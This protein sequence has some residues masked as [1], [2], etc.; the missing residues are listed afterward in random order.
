MAEDPRQ[1]TLPDLLVKLGNDSP[2]PEQCVFG[3]ESHALGFD[4]IQNGIHD[5]FDDH[6]MNRTRD[7]S[8]GVFTRSFLFQNYQACINSSSLLAN[9]TTIGFSSRTDNVSFC[10]EDFSLLPTRV[11]PA[12]E[13]YLYNAALRNV[14]IT[15]GADCG[16]HP[17]ACLQKSRRKV[18]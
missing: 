2:E 17:L 15:S 1:A 6:K 9:V 11:A 18:C 10:L 16:H 14:A 3:L 5:W 8:T 13:P 4:P 7:D 12:G